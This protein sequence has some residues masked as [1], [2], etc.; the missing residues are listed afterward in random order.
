MMATTT[1]PVIL[2]LATPEPTAEV[3]PCGCI[4]TAGGFHPC[5]AC[6]AEVWADLAEVY[7]DANDWRLQ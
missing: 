1:D 7:S 4:M 5:A 3:E 6:K 2:A